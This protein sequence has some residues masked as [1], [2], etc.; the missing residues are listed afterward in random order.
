MKTPHCLAL[1][2]F[3]FIVFLNAVPPLA[4][5]PNPNPSPVPPP[6]PLTPLAKRPQGVT[7]NSRI[8]RR[9][10]LMT[11]ENHP[12]VSGSVHKLP[13]MSESSLA[14]VSRKDVRSVLIEKP[15]PPPRAP[16]TVI[17][18]LPPS[19][20]SVYPSDRNTMGE[21]T[22]SIEAWYVISHMASQSNVVGSAQ[23]CKLILLSVPHGTGAPVYVCF[24]LLTAMISSR[25]IRENRL[26][27]YTF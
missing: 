7:C 22:L 9:S 18:T 20:Q 17:S 23:V 15:R 3:C 6:E 4:P 21:C 12:S 25:P 1:L 10:Q 16:S 14:P 24:L 13:I 5:R 27:L 11:S 2:Y 19:M 26:G 8:Y